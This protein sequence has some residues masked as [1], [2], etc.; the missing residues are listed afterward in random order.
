M[1]E[2]RQ[3][4]RVVFQV[5]VVV[6][7]AATQLP[8]CEGISQDISLGGVF[9]ESSVEAVIGSEVRVRLVLPGLGDV[10]LPGFIR[11]VKPNGFGVQF[12]LLGARET[13]AIGRLV[14]GSQP[15]LH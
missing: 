10:A 1:R 8:V 7:D 11:W 5:P 4:Q 13:H 15:A 9:L 2:K 12:G 14:R 3:H 6:V